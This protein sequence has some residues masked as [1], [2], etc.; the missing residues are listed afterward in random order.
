MGRAFLPDHSPKLPIASPPIETASNVVLI[1]NFDSFVWNIYQYLRLEGAYVTVYR[2]NEISL[3]E[4]VDLLPTQLV[5]SP[6]PG[7]PRTDSGI[8]K[9]A[10]AHFAGKIPILGVCLGQQCM[11]D[12]WGGDVSYAGEIFHGKTS[13]LQHDG[14]GVYQGI[15][16]GVLVT[17]YHSLAG[18]YQT[19]PECLEITSW[20]SH[21]GNDSKKGTIMGV[22]HKEYLIEGVQFHPESILTEGGNFMLKNFVHLQGGTWAEND[23]LQKKNDS[24]KENILETIFAHRKA[25]ISLQK[26][27]PSLRPKDLQD[28]YDLGLAPPLISFIDRLTKSPFPLSL[29]AEIKRASPSKGLISLSINAPAQAR[30]Y[31]LAGASVISVLTEPKWFKGNID[32]LRNVRLSL[33]GMINRPAILRKEFIFEEYQI[34]ESRLAGADTVLLIVKMLDEKKLIELFQYSQS[35]GME[36]LVEVNT[37]EEMK[38]ALKIGS[39]VIGV[40]NRNLINFEV[41]L[42]TTNR[43]LDK[44]PEGITICALSGIKGAKDVEAYLK[45]RVSAVLVGEALMRAQNPETFVQGLFKESKPKKKTSQIPLLIKICGMR[46]AE[47]AAEAIKAGANLIGIILAPGKRRSI[48]PEVAMAISSIVHRSRSLSDSRSRSMISNRYENQASDFFENSF[49]HFP[50]DYPLLVGVFQNQPLSEILE[51]QKLYKL[52]IVQLHGN[53]PLE[54]ARIIP[55]PVLR[56]FLPGQPSLR[57]R[58]FHILPLLDSDSGGSGKRLC[59]SAV[60]AVL[61]KDSSLRVFLAGGLNPENVKDVIEEAAELAEKIIGVDVSSGIEENGIQSI[62]KIQAFISASKSI[63]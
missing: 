2:N 38:T 5:I 61:S 29:M 3:K 46:N 30:A 28:A 40:N 14:K 31:A 58:G 44:V 62:A 9:D 24:K 35:L 19:L 15:P 59:M 8:S 10:I 45:N 16:Q 26:E 33:E 49:L 1:D 20:V 47:V 55:V 6:G 43:L 23:K 56:S 48:S 53:E 13:P 27:M 42:E 34:L 41:D 50:R 63:R 12:L 39:K 21:N 36:P 37:H 52:D 25:A 51:L 32:D 57:T 22:R 11:I 17:R 60:K 4:L 7:H 54:W 18:T